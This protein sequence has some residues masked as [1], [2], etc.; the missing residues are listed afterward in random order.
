MLTSAKELIP[1]QSRFARYANIFRIDKQAR[2][3][4]LPVTVTFDDHVRLVEEVVAF[5][6]SHEQEALE[7]TGKRNTN[8]PDLAIPRATRQSF[9]IA[10]ES[11][12][13][14]ANTMTEIG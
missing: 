9:V 12:T 10:L 13:S 5:L 8:G 7:R 11:L 4:D 3:D 14:L 6:S 2:E 1:L